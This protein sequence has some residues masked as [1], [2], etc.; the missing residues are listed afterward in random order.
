MKANEGKAKLLE[1]LAARRAQP[2]TAVQMTRSLRLKGKDAKQLAGWIDAL[3]EEGRLAPVRGNRYALAEAADLVTGALSCSRSGDGFVRSEAGG[4]DVFVPRTALGTALPG[5]L[6]VVRTAPP[7]VAGEGRVKAQGEVIRI[8]RRAARD[9]VGT[10]QRTGS[11]HVV[12]PLDPVYKQDF[13][14]RDAGDARVGDRV[15]MRFVDWA[16]PHVS[17]EAEIV[18]VLGPAD[19]PGVD[20]LSVARHFDLPGPFAEGV[21]RE[22]ETVASRLESPGAREDL[23][24]LTVIT[25]DPDDARDFDDALSLEQDG[26][27]NRVLGV[28]IAD[29]SHFVTPGSAL[30]AEALARGTS[31]YFVDQVIPMLP[32][33]LSNGVCSLK[34]GVPRLAFSAFLTVSAEGRIVS[35]RFAKTVI[36]SA[37][38]LTYRQ[39]QGFLQA[40]AAPTSGAMPPDI[41]RLL[42]ALSTLAQTFRQARFERHALELDM[43]ECR[44][45]LDPDGEVERV[46]LETTDASHQLV[47]ECMIAANEAVARELANRGAPGI[48]RVHEAPDEVRLQELEAQL[49]ELGVR[50]GNLSQR[51]ALSR[52]LKRI[53]NHPLEH[54]V[55]VAVLRSM[56]RAVYEAAC[57][58]HFGLATP[59]YLHFTSPIRRY[60]DL[61]VHRQL[62]RA[63][64]NRVSGV[65]PKRHL[66]R[67]AAHCSERERRAEDAERALEEIKKYRFLQRQLS[68]GD[69]TAYT[70]VV[71]GVTNFGLF[72]EV[73]DLQLQGLIHISSLSERFVRHHRRSGTLT[74]GRARYAVGS[75]LDV[76]V[77]RVDLENRRVDFVP[78]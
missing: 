19:R 48:F 33:Q 16:N 72:V 39:A 4:S 1:L 3:V 76:V 8:I 43:P 22:A 20:S 30:D 10:L 78:A 28:H 49:S 24:A 42:K 25:I 9:L 23:Q 41:G 52:L 60:P 58:G 26:R 38:R 11:F 31:V 74:A 73:A 15:V 2:L 66:E 17:P 47:E 45:H 68:A 21:M 69:L 14:I 12:A 7:A 32:E 64:L 35:Q 77:N 59:F 18:E 51:G 36:R 55:R 37:C 5:D 70:S 44:L 53:R 46:T 27:G 50:P 34:P 67:I 29:V 71:V 6:V 56:N 54:H 65:P 57:R 13:Y 75:R 62:E 63:L 61:V 40:P